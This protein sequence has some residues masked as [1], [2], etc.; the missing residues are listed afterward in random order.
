MGLSPDHL[1][2]HLSHFSAAP[3]T[4]RVGM[5][6]DYWSCFQLLNSVPNN[7]LPLHRTIGIF[8]QLLGFTSVSCLHANTWVSPKYP[9]PKCLLRLCPKPKRTR[10]CG[11]G[12]G[13][14]STC[15][16]SIPNIFYGF[17]Y[18]QH[19]L[20]LPEPLAYAKGSGSGT[21]RIC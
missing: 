10:A 7:Y 6:L 17:Q 3:L 20:N 12:S 21:R 16:G 9:N 19:M 14:L 8:T 4:R 2:S 18:L 15:S 1:A 5:A 11:R 13:I